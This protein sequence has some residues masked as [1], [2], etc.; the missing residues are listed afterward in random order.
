[1]DSR[2]LLTTVFN[3]IDKY[4]WNILIIVFAILI[5][6]K[7]LSLIK[8]SFA[9]GINETN[10]KALGVVMLIPIV[11]VL[12]AGNSISGETLAALLGAIAGYIFGVETKVDRRPPEE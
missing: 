12:G 11:L 1:M 10:F 7:G 3:L 2:Q 9:N 8:P 6:F 4:G 5:T